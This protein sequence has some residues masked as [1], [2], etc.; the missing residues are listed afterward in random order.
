[1]KPSF[2]F[3][4]SFFSFP[5]SLTLHFHFRLPSYT[6]EKIKDVCD[7]R[8]NSLSG[9]P[10]AQQKCCKV[11][12]SLRCFMQNCHRLKAKIPCNVKFWEYFE[13]A[14]K[15][16]GCGVA[17]A[18][19][20][21]RCGRSDADAIATP[22]LVE[23]TGPPDD[24]GG[25]GGGG[26]NGSS[27]GLIA[28]LVI[29]VLLC[30]IGGGYYFFKPTASTTTTKAITSKE[31]IKKQSS[32]RR[33]KPKTRTKATRKVS[34]NALVGG[35]KMLSSKSVSQRSLTN[36]HRATPG[37]RAASV[38]VDC[39]DSYNSHAE[40]SAGEVLPTEGFG[41]ARGANVNPDML[42]KVVK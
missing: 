28:G 40:P 33:S 38:A 14:N 18:D 22:Y 31:V 29:L 12:M 24:D 13:S 25:G 42:R 30:A 21:K 2:F 37:K 34:S 10:P 39:Q 35:G 23:P 17:A 5:L 6:Y 16:F 4:F 9:F 19:F 32:I 3:F 11:Y 20:P 8:K 1:M 41:L 27:A 26:K 7:S 15:T 36:K